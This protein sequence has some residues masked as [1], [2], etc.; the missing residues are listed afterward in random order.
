MLAVLHVLGEIEDKG[1]GKLK[2][3]RQTNTKVER[4]RHTVDFYVDEESHL[5]S[6]LAWVDERGRL[7]GTKREKDRVR[8]CAYED[9]I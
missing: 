4:R 3:K 9:D 8:K 2:K 1:L 6:A 7:A 5:H